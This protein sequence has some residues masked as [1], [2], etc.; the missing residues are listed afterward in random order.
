[1]ATRRWDI[2]C[3]IWMMMQNLT[4]TETYH[5]KINLFSHMSLD[6][7]ALEAPNLLFHWISSSL[8]C[9]QLTQAYREQEHSLPT[10]LLNVLP[11]WLRYTHAHTSKP[12]CGLAKNFTALQQHLARTGKVNEQ[13]WYVWKHGSEHTMWFTVKLL[14]QLWGFREHTTHTNRLPKGPFPQKKKKKNQQ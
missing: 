5:C 3:P 2:S 13:E 8:L 12:D 9:L 11:R 6:M 10:A 14:S 7:F 1:M 4:G